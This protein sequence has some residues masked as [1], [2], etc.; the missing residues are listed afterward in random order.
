MVN[1]RL[2]HDRHDGAKPLSQCRDVRTDRFSRAGPLRPD[3]RRTSSMNSTPP[4]R[5]LLVHPRLPKREGRVVHALCP[6][7]RRHAG[8]PEPLGGDR[9]RSHAK[10]K[11]PAR[12]KEIPSNRQPGVRSDGGHAP[13]RR[14]SRLVV[15]IHDPRRSCNNLGAIPMN[16]V[17]NPSSWGGRAR[18]YPRFRIG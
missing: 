2:T 12:A 3:K 11:H 4:G 18:F 5:T 7:R 15:L 9:V 1:T 8:G 17:A 13:L 14:S 6:E 16:S 10:H